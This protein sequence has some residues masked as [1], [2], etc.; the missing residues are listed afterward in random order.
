MHIEQHSHCF[1]HCFGVKT[2]SKTPFSPPLMKP[3]QK[4][5]SG[6][7]YWGFV[8]LTATLITAV[9]SPL[10]MAF[11]DSTTSIDLDAGKAP[12]LLTANWILNVIFYVD[13]VVN[14]T[15]FVESAG[16]VGA[17]K[18]KFSDATQ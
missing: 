15:T 18:H 10:E 5:G 17:M 1:M 12:A 14:F 11:L 4:K 13:I 7:R 3:G 8:I 16:F 9:L 2:L 6:A